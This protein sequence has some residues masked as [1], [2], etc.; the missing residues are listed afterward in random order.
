[1]HP[2]KESQKMNHNVRTFGSDDPYAVLNVDRN[3]SEA[4]IQSSYKRLSKSFHPD[5][6]PHQH[7]Q[8]NDMVAMDVPSD[9]HPRDPNLQDDIS[10]Q[11]IFVR[12]KNAY[13]ILTDPILRL[14]YDEFGYEAVQFVRRTMHASSLDM[15]ALYPKLQRLY[16]QT[17]N[18]IQQQQNQKQVKAEIARILRHNHIEKMDKIHP[19]GVTIE[20]PCDLSMLPSPYEDIIWSNIPDTLLQR[21]GSTNGSIVSVS[22]SSSPSSSNKL[23]TSLRIQTSIKDGLGKA[24]TNLSIGYRP[25]IGTHISTSLET[26]PERMKLH[27]SSA[28]SGIKIPMRLSCSS[29]RTFQ[30]STI[31]TVSAQTIVMSSTTQSSRAPVALSLVSYRN[32]WIHTT[33]PLRASWAIGMGSDRTFHY[34]LLS[35]MTLSNDYP[36]CVVKLNLGLDAYP[37]KLSGQHDFGT[38]TG[39]L[40]L[41]LGPSG[42]KIKATL[43]RFL[44]SYSKWT[45]GLQH[46]TNAGLSWMLELNRGNFT[47]RIPILLCSVGDPFY[48]MRMWYICLLTG[49]VDDVL[50]D[51]SQYD[52]LGKSQAPNIRSSVRPP[53]GRLRQ[54]AEQQI[55]LMKPIAMKNMERESN[56]NGLVIYQAHYFVH[57]GPSFDARIQLQ[58]LVQDSTLRLPEGSKSTLLGFYSLITP[59]LPKP[60]SLWSWNDWFSRPEILPNVVPQLRIRYTYEDTVF[61]I[62]VHDTDPLVLPNQHAMPLGPKNQVT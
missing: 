5:K 37:L 44:T 24:S 48:S 47:F 31:V 58:F 40:S 49:L 39:F 43:S 61:E 51:I 1:M 60:R 19:I 21:I 25:E 4:A 38:R 16:Y 36:K 2:E 14:A 50:N 17:N 20:L 54:D 8:Q 56:C 6:H 26:I 34:G 13:D 11:E 30:N 42:M 9:T 46:V 7:Q 57:G 18:S 28:S 33:T 3:A 52:S 23:D 15:D 32:L 55:L 12:L 59:P 53:L 27:S 35:L 10:S 41:A 29:T 45:M 62:T 22:T